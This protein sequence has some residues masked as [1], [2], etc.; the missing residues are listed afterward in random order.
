MLIW[1]VPPKIKVYEALSAIA[2]GRVR[3]LSGKKSKTRMPTKGVAKVISSNRD[4]EYTVQWNFSRSEIVSDDN[5]SRWQG[6]LGYPSIAI[7]MLGKKLPY[8]SQIATKLKGINWNA[9]NKK[10]KRD[11]EE[12]EEYVLS[13]IAE[14]KATQTK[15][16]DFVEKVYKKIQELKLKRLSKPT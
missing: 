16:K 9:L 15:I 14:K 13:Q 3:I 6:Y 5:G 7:L 10:L 1:K 11:Y 2:D 12:V 8:S 4:R